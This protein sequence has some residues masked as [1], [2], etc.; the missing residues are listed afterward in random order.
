[1]SEQ[2]DPGRTPDHPPTRIQAVETLLRTVI[3][4]VAQE[5][6]EL[7]AALEVVSARVDDLEP[8][9]ARPAARQPEPRAWADDATKQDWTELASWVDWLARA[10]DLQP[11]RAVLPCWPAHPGAV[12]ELAALRTAWHEASAAG[13]ARDLNHELADWHDRL[14][15]CLLR[16]REAF[17]QKNCQDRHSDPRPGRT[18]D[19]GLLKT[20]LGRAPDPSPVVAPAPE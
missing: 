7:R 15:R 20:A 12:E 14:H 19:P 1:V 9:P 8:A 11:S 10:Y 13:G 5:T 3:R 18:T 4:G 6:E 17:Q 16:L 2:A